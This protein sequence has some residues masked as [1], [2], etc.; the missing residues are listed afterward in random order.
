MSGQSPYINGSQS[1]QPEAT[2]DSFNFL[3]SPVD[4]ELSLELS[5]IDLELMHHYT[6]KT[7][8]T[9]SA[10]E[11]LEDIWKDLV[12]QLALK[13]DYL[14]H[15]LLAVTA[16]HRAISSPVQ[17]PYEKYAL[18]HQNRA[19][20]L[21]QPVVS[22][23]TQSNCN[24]FFMFTVFALRYALGIPQVST[25]HLKNDSVDQ[26]L[27]IYALLRGIAVIVAPAFAW[28][29]QGSLSPLLN[30]HLRYT[31]DVEVGEIPEDIRSALDRLDERNK[32]QADTE[33]EAVSS[34]CSSAIRGLRTCYRRMD[35]YPIE[36]GPAL[37]WLST[38]D[39]EFVDLIKSHDPMALAVFAYFGV[40][41]H[42]ASSSWWSA[43]WGRHV[44]E[45]TSHV[46]EDE[47]HDLVW[48]AKQKVEVSFSTG[49]K[50]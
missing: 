18:Q 36:E 35:Q 25:K 1:A 11:G 41:L 31:T 13:H 2:A 20:T 42:T 14:M 19:L 15:S 32:A 6:L 22:G 16:L 30:R 45:A 7:S 3:L 34:L 33:D 9:I 46:L 5:L 10:T 26:I 47:W 39:S 44:V 50:S 40:A 48:V 4:Q 8:V 12:P 29:A 37:Y 24:A 43:G 27:E 17:D 49:L 38:V 21:F 23:I 28:I